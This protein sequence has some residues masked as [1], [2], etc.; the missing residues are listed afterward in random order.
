V[1]PP[2]A[3]PSRI[4]FLRE[5][6]GKVKSRAHAAACMVHA[7]S[8]GHAAPWS[9]SAARAGDQNPAPV[10]PLRDK[11]RLRKPA[12]SLQLQSGVASR[13]DSRGR[14]R[15]CN[16]QASQHRHR[17][18]KKEKAHIIHQEE[19]NRRSIWMEIPSCVCEIAFR[20]KHKGVVCL[21]IVVGKDSQSE[22]RQQACRCR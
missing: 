15:G 17:Q 19:L 8:R 12:C 10:Q 13:R 16:L 3:H 6:Q 21:C 20:H 11:P 18:C 4:N 7:L 14:E 1:A 2:F 22:K 9:S 5:Q